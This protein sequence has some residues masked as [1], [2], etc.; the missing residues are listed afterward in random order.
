MGKLIPRSDGS[1]EF[2]FIAGGNLWKTNGNYTIQLSYVAFDFEITINYVGGG[3]VIPI[4]K[5]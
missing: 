1:F 4:L 3:Q 2:D 5:F